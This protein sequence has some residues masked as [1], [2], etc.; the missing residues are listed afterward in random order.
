MLKSI[1]NIAKGNENKP[2]NNDANDAMLNSF[3]STSKSMGILTSFFK[4]IYS[5]IIQ[6][7]ESL[8]EKINLL[9]NTFKNNSKIDDYIQF[10]YDSTLIHLY[11]MSENLEKYNELI[12]A[13]LNDFKIEYDNKT[14]LYINN[15]SSLRKAFDEER[16][17]VIFYH[18]K[19]LKDVKEYYKADENNKELLNKIKIDLDIDKKSYKYQLDYFNYFYQKEFFNNYNQNIDELKKIESSNNI[20]LRNIFYFFTN[21]LNSFKKSIDSYI[22]TINS[23]FKHNKAEQNDFK[24]DLSNFENSYKSLNKEYNIINKN[25]I[26]KINNFHL[27]DNKIILDFNLISG[28]INTDNKQEKFNK[29]LK[30]Y[31]DYLDKKDNIP[32]KNICE[33][34][35]LLITSN[36]KEFYL[37]FIEEFLKEYNKSSYIEINNL[38]N[39]SHLSYVFQSIISSILNDNKIFLLLLL[40]QITFH[41]EEQK[42]LLSF[43]INNFWNN[44]FNVMV[45]FILTKDNNS[46]NNTLIDESIKKIIKEM[47]YDEINISNE[48]SANSMKYKYKQADKLISNIDAFNSTI[49]TYNQSYNSS[50]NECFVKIHKIILL[51]ISFLINYN[52]EIKNSI[53]L[54]VQICNKFSFN[55]H[56]KEYYITFL[57]NYSYSIRNANN[58]GYYSKRNVVN[59]NDSILVSF[60]KNKIIIGNIIKYIDSKNLLKFL[61]LNKKYYKELKDSVYKTYL[62]H[63][64]NINYNQDINIKRYIAIWKNLL[65]YKEIKEKYPYEENKS[66]ALKIMY[67]RRYNSDYSVI[68]VDCIRTYFI[69]DENLEEKRNSLNSILK[70]IMLLNKDCNYCQGMNFLVGFI[71]SICDNNEEEA[72]YLSLCFFKNT[73]YKIIFLNELELLRLNF[74]V[75]DKLLYIYVPV[76]YTLLISNKIY[77]IYYISPWI[78]TLFTYLINA[79]LKIESFIKIFNSFLIHGWKSIFN[80]SLNIFNNYE[81]FILSQKEQNLLQFVSSELS[82]KFINDLNNNEYY[83]LDEI[84]ISKKLLEEIKKEF[85]RFLFLVDEFD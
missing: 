57:K 70:T 38:Y 81:K 14:L 27:N 12:I 61:L 8:S 28:D 56:L 42:I 7:K 35:S 46:K 25:D 82:V 76:L 60:D 21:N 39:F 33:I 32:L 29:I 67:N 17:K 23:I 79:Q 18:K 22:S 2:N 9:K 16:N 59:G 64:D 85:N 58:I 34:N 66:K 52:Y 40:G 72:F 80:I 62:K 54:L 24:D 51:Y 84:K 6:F 1:I 4:D 45:K 53:E 43:K 78:L 77:S 36:S 65:N 69:N 55:L 47:S 10:F 11:K 20:F 31:F 48:R 13:P 74:A 3:I 26:G 50:I 73:S 44:I 83:N 63:L 19:Y 49:F 75:F 41:Y 68:D 37:F 71:L 5:N 15:L 30:E